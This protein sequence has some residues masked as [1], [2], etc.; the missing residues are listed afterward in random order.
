VPQKH[1]NK[2]WEFNLDTGKRKFKTW[3]Y[4]DTGQ[5]IESRFTPFKVSNI[6]EIIQTDTEQTENKSKPIV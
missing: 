5:D 6:K 1:L 3:V 4:S 2:M